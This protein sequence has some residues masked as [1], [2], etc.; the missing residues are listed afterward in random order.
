[1]NEPIEISRNINLLFPPFRESILQGIQLAHAEGLMVHVFEAWRSIE[2]Q[3]FLYTQGRSAPGKIVTNA[4]PGLSF[5]SYGLAVDL[6]FDSKPETPG[7][8][9]TWAGNY[10]RVAEIMASLGIE[11]LRME[12]GHF[13]MSFGMTI[14]QIKTYAEARG[15]LGLWEYLYARAK[16]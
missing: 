8:Q 2:R 13:Q 15:L 9:W 11:T 5:H 7:V 16:K 12:Q 3:A 10:K 14:A 4:K 6:V 1:M